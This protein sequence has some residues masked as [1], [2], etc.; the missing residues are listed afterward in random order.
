MVLI[1]RLHIWTCILVYSA[2]PVLDSV[3]ICS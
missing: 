1:D 3:D 2:I